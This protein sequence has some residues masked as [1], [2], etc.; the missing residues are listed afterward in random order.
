VSAN[1]TGNG[2]R[3]PRGWS[4]RAHIALLVLVFLLTAAGAI[5]YVSAQSARDGRRDA[6]H[7]A[8]FAART[9]ARELGGA[10]ATLKATVKSVAGA[11]QIGRAL[12]SPQ[13]CTLQFEASGGMSGHIDILRADGSVACSSRTGAAGRSRAGYQRAAW[14]S[15]ARERALFLAPVTDDAVGGHAALA[16]SPIAG[17]VVA[18]FLTLEPTGAGLARLYGGGRPVEFVVTTRD[19]RRTVIAR[20]IDPAR[21]IGRPARGSDFVRASAAAE[22]PDLDGT[23]RLYAD[24]GVPGTDWTFSAGEDR[25]EALAGGARLRNRQLVIILVG[26]ALMLAAAAV[27]YRRVAAPVIRLGA[28]V[29]STSALSPPEPVQR[30]GGAAEVAALGDDVNGLI[31]AVGRELTERQ[32]AEESARASE[33]NHRL[34]FESSPVAMWI[35]DRDTQALLEVND[36][37]LALYGYARAEFLSLRSSEIEP[38]ATGDDAPVRHRRKDGSQFEV[39]V[40]AHAVTFA[41]REVRLVLAED[42]GERE[43]LERQLRQAQRMEAI[44]R[45]AGGVAHDFN[46]LLTAILGNADLLLAQVATG[47]PRRVEAVEIKEAGERASALT[48]QLLTFGRGQAVDTMVLD[49]NQVIRALEPMLRRLIRSNIEI[50]TRL[51]PDGRRVRADRG[52]IEQVIVNLVV[53]A[54]DAMPEGGELTIATSEAELDEH[55][56]GLH[57]AGPAAPGRFTVLEIADTGVGMD[58]ETLAHVFEPFFTTKGEERGTGL[59]LA[60]VYG[61]VHQNGGW[62]WAYSEPGRGTTFKTYLPAVTAPATVAPPAARPGA[63]LSAAGLTALLVEDD[64]SVRAIVRR[65]LEL[66]G[67]AIL[68][69]TRGEEAIVLGEDGPPGSIDVLVTDTIIPGPGGAELANR[70]RRRHP[71]LRT[72]IMSGYTEPVGGTQPLGPGTEF[73]A[74][75]FSAT[76]LHTK[77]ATL[78]HTRSRSPGA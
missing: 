69:A 27:V 45:L 51:S 41:G 21:W 59:G 74:K 9:A 15:R 31:G 38:E 70:L 32:R 35:A 64:P 50:V 8:R 14:L 52:Q 7:D 49:L 18:A 12:T 34:L 66:E 47:D 77:L 65:M 72:L 55:Y 30:P 19:A 40:I 57:A 53:N 56:A 10:V 25:E 43:R 3:R 39:R 61:I 23:R 68:E 29:R 75:P 22:R 78:L 5:A 37:A 54:G 46:N 48:R 63:S 13:A 58:E 73:L 2:E 20:S 71:A 76:D 11:P 6:E 44:G 42:V 28:A 17:G 60:T 67:F 4:L 33:R 36:A 26:L 16:A 1:T 62:L 24:T